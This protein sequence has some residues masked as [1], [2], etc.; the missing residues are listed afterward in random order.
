MMLKFKKL[1]ETDSKII[2]SI[3]NGYYGHIEYDKET[4][5]IV[6]YD[7]NNQ[8]I[9]SR[10]MRLPFYHVINNGFPEEYIYAAG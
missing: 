6:V 4:K 5:N 8:Q 9:D 3:M 2:Y 10:A 7:E 1:S